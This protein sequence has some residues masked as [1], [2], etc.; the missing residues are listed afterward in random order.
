MSLF[1]E[2]WVVVFPGNLPVYITASC[3][4][5]LYKAML[6]LSLETRESNK[7]LTERT[8]YIHNMKVKTKWK[9]IKLYIFGKTW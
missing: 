4:Y 7:G 8:V 9:E 5:T 2:G 3:Q 6:Q 1:S